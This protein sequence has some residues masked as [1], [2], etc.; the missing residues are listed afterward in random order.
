MDADISGVW[1]LTSREGRAL[2]LASK[3]QQLRFGFPERRLDF[4]HICVSGANQSAL[5]IVQSPDSWPS[6][7]VCLV[8]PQFCGLS[9][10]IAAW[11]SAFEAQ[12]FSAQ[13]FHALKPKV[14]NGFGGDFIAIDDAET[15]KDPDRLLTLINIVTAQNGRLLLAAHSPP[16][17]WPVSS[18]DLK[19]RLNAMTLAEI[20]APDEALLRQRLQAS[21][22]RDFLML[23]ED[24]LKYLVP[25]LDLSYVAVENFIARLNDAVIETGRAPSVPLAREVLEEMGLD[26][27]DQRPLL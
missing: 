11:A 3:I 8:G 18:A 25:R 23:D 5:R 7:V 14:L 16:P 4:S 15:L 12:A 19:S 20:D 6:P 27:L 26:S 13:A 1:K 2:G 24:T 21:A 22:R 9:T 10:I 17:Q